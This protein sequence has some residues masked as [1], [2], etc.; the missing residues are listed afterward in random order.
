MTAPYFPTVLYCESC[1]EIEWQARDHQDN[2]ERDGQHNCKN[3]AYFVPIPLV[4]AILPPGIRIV[5]FSRSLT[6]GDHSRQ[7]LCYCVGYNGAVVYWAPWVHCDRSVLW[8]TDRRE[9]VVWE[10]GG[11]RDVH[12]NWILWIV[13]QMPFLNVSFCWWKMNSGAATCIHKN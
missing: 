10:R 1:A 2:C 8:D 12:D 13:L 6:H 4:P 11:G 7:R 9:V 5:R 3:L